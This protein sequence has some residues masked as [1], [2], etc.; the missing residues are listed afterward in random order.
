[1][2]A[3]PVLRRAGFG[4]YTGKTLLENPV[5]YF[6]MV[7]QQ[8]EVAHT[9]LGE[10]SKAWGPP[11]TNVEPLQQG[12]MM[13]EGEDLKQ[14][15]SELL[16]ISREFAGVR[17]DTEIL[18]KAVLR[19]L[20]TLSNKTKRAIKAVEKLEKAAASEKGAGKAGRK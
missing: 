11:M 8:D 12:V 4:Q 20:K 17:K 18:M 5:D 14:L 13:S 9:S 1:M 10:W 16:L 3:H 2:G 19:S 15:K 6:I 7:R